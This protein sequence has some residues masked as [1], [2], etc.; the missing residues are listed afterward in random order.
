MKH[1]SG[2][3]GALVGG[4]V[5]GEAFGHHLV[6]VEPGAGESPEWYLATPNLCQSLSIS[7][8]L[9]QPL[10]ICTKLWRSLFTPINCLSIFS[11]LFALYQSL[12]IFIDLNQYFTNPYQ[13]LPTSTNLYQPLPISISR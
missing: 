7:I 12:A 8:S 6:G 5:T 9:Y 13:S 1:L 11:K 3:R 2:S 10:A 4:C